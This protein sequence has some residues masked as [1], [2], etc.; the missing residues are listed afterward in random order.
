MNKDLVL[1]FIFL[2]AAVALGLLGA[3]V[4]AVMG[5]LILASI[6]GVASDILTAIREGRE[7][8]HEK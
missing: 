5:F 7:P 8:T 6:H 3:P 4:A 1:C 2:A